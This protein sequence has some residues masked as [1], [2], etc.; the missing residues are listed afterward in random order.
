MTKRI[1]LAVTADV[2]LG[3]MQG[4]PEH[5][6]SEGW[7]VHVVSSP[8]PNGERLA[9]SG[10]VTFHPI[11]MSRN[12]SPLRDLH[13][14]V[15][16]ICLLREIGPNLTSVGTPKAGLLGGLAAVLTR[17][18]I[19]VY[20]LRG[21]RYETSRWHTRF[22]LRALERMTCACSHD[23][24]AVS[25]SLRKLAMRDHLAP[26]NKIIVLGS[27]SSNGVDLVRFSFTREERSKAKRDRW[28]HSPE[29]PVVGFIGRIHPDK[30][31]T[32]LAAAIERL[33]DKSIPGRLL[34]V[35]STDSPEG[36]I[37]EKRLRDSG[38][39]VEFVGQVPDVAPYLRLIDVLCLPTKREGFPNVVIEAAAA[40][41]PTVATLATGVED[42]IVHG[43]TGLICNVRRPDRFASSL[44]TLITRPEVAEELGANARKRVEER[45]LR[46]DVW[47]RY[48]AFYGQRLKE[49]HGMKRDV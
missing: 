46:N 1:L 28:P 26:S 5:L 2:S 13:A 45:F 7:E 31:L 18:P 48:S 32:L 4:F 43:E 8:G 36:D 19:R 16:W 14:L 29:T 42:S 34:V 10:T 20:L 24:I 35:G 30:G 40:Q 12:P 15:Q 6:S 41:I 38:F 23:V 27:G 9:A 49:W 25:H 37:L 3:L 17:V 11:E 47:A 22:A 21:V 39:E 33:A 44:E